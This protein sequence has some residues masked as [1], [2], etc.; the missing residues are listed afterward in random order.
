[1]FRS[2]DAV[3]PVV[4]AHD[5]PRLSFFDRAFEAR[6]IDLPQRTLVHHG[7]YRH[8]AMLLVVDGK[9]LQRRA[10]SP[11]LHALDMAG[12]DL[13]RQIRIFREVFEVPAA[14][15]RALDVRSR[16]EQ[17]GH[18]LRLA[19]FAERFAHAANQVAVPRRRDT[20]CRREAG[21]GH[22]VA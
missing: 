4:R 12:R 20:R 11:A 3:H 7:I 14:Q 2:V 5:R 9:M 22:A 15:R 17:H 1:M 6:Q 18:V 21:R 19:F 13:R 10:D 16:S 8:A